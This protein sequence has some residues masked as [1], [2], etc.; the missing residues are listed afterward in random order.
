MRMLVQA[1]AAQRQPAGPQVADPQ[2]AQEIPP[3]AVHQGSAASGAFARG[4]CP[5]S[6]PGSQSAAGPQPAGGLQCQ[7]RCA[8]ALL[9][10]HTTI[11]LAT[12]Y[13]PTH[14]QKDAAASPQP[15]ASL[16]AGRVCN[17]VGEP[18]CLS[19][20]GQF[21]PPAHA[22][23]RPRFTCAHLCSALRHSS[24]AGIARWQ[25]CCWGVRREQLTSAAVVHSLPAG[26]SHAGLRRL[27]AASSAGGRAVAAWHCCLLAQV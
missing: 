20:P 10:L 27:C 12:A 25:G 1:A 5:P 13:M 21:G 2:V 15:A 22:H 24:L 6:Q 19:C 7:G 8:I 18:L 14:C 16:S 23:C 9:Q 11:R 17:G 26:R 4:C 3:G